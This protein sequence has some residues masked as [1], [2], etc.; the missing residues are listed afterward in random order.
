MDD[1]IL[2]RCT[3]EE[4]LIV[5]IM[6][7]EGGVWIEMNDINIELVATLGRIIEEE[8]KWSAFFRRY[9]KLLSGLQLN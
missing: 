2:F 7:N 5:D 9:K 3:I 8:I 4:V 1:T 6:Q